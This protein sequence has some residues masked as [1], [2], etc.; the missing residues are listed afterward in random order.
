MPVL[1]FFSGFSGCQVIGIFCNFSLLK[2]C[3]TYVAPMLP[4]YGRNCLLICPNFIEMMGIQTNL[5]FKT[6]LKLN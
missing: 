6:T 5:K 1:M 3:K 2:S 4:P